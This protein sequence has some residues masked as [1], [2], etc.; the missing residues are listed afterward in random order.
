MPTHEAQVRHY[1]PDVENLIKEVNIMV[2]VFKNKF[3]ANVDSASGF[4]VDFVGIYDVFVHVDQRRRHY[5][6]YHRITWGDLK[7]VSSVCYW[8]LRY[9]PIVR[10]D[11]F[12]SVSYALEGMEPTNE[13]V[14]EKFAIFMLIHVVNSYRRGRGLPEISLV[15]MPSVNMGVE[16]PH[17]E[18]NLFTDIL[19]FL[20]NRPLSQEALLVMV[21]SLAKAVHL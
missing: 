3:L 18:T 2:S 10:L 13:A 5:E 12:H 20:Q 9:K 8:L 17:R 14:C 1:A 7:R 4:L 21:E 11:G 15:S 16:R 6:Y 19:Y